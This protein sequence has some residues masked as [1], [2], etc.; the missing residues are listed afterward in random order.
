MK[1]FVVLLSQGCYFRD[2]WGLRW[3]AN[4]AR[5]WQ[6]LV[7]GHLNQTF[8]TSSSPSWGHLRFDSIFFHFSLSKKAFPLL[9]IPFW[10]VG[11]QISA[12]LCSHQ[13]FRYP[14][15]FTLESSVAEEQGQARAFALF[16]I[17]MIVLCMCGNYAWW[18]GQREWVLGSR[19]LLTNFRTMIKFYKSPSHILL[20][21]CVC[22]IFLL[23]L[24]M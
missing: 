1:E 6:F 11:I 4:A 17:D 2:H 9:T 8:T 22:Y 16:W 5:A 10:E 19:L 3:S 24:Q 14:L 23:T 12:Y 21:F 13:G 15:R 7:I 18:E 20:F